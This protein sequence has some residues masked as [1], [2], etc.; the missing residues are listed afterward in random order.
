MIYF[1]KHFK[2]IAYFLAMLILFQSC[3]TY[4]RK[5][6]PIEEAA[7][8]KNAR[9]K[10]I[11]KDGNVHYLKWIEEKDGNAYSIINTKRIFLKK[12]KIEK[13]MIYRP[14]PLTVPLEEALVHEG[15]VEILT[16][17]YTE[18]KNKII[19]SKGEFI[20]IEDRGEFI[21]G[22]KVVNNSKEP[23]IFIIPIDQIEAIK[24]IDKGLNAGTTIIISLSAITA[25][26]FFV[27][28]NQ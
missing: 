9:M 1:L 10:V 27:V 15:K 14:D 20:D 26:L 7:A 22:I 16:W 2:G 5:S 8:R 24:L 4:K 21:R 23:E 25:L 6:T 28:K 13:Y 11:T 12:D 3:A 18:S 17:K 19:E